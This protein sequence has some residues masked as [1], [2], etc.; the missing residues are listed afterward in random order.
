[1]S[2]FLRRRQFGQFR[3]NH[4]T[5]PCHAALLQEMTVYEDCRR[6]SDA[7]LLPLLQIGGNPLLNCR[8]VLVLVELGHIQ[9]DLLNQFPDFLGIQPVEIFI[10][11]I[12]QRPEFP[13]P[14]GR[15]SGGCRGAG[16]L[17]V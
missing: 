11:Q 1:L 13:L 16:I 8:I 7:D 9:P 14:L 10:Q 6:T 17:M 4:L 5:D 15:Q 12:M 3:F 2:G